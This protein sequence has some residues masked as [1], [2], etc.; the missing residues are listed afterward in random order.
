MVRDAGSHLLKRNRS[1]FQEVCP[2]LLYLAFWQLLFS[3]LM[4][5]PEWK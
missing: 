5:P 2:F 1:T 4:E 3:W